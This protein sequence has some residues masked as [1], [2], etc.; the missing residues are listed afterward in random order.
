[1]KVSYSKVRMLNRAME[2]YAMDKHAEVRIRLTCEND[3]W[4]P[5]VAKQTINYNRLGM[6][7]VILNIIA[8]I[9]K[10]LNDNYAEES[11]LEADITAEECSQI[12]ELVHEV[13]VS[14]NSKDIYH[15]LVK[16][17]NHDKL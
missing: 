9:S 2:K 11:F 1:M 12:D 17:E 10:M 6:F 16:E 8:E 14:E 15:W 13:F 7:R 4:K 3:I 5:E